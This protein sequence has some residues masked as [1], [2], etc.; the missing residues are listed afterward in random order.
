MG[1]SRPKRLGMKHNP[2]LRLMRRTPSSADSAVFDI[3]RDVESPRRRLLHGC[4]N[5]NGGGE[6]DGER[7]L[8]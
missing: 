7:L 4:W 3:L 5:G 2:E 8:P 6:P 1:R